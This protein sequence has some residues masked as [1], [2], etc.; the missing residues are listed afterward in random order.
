MVVNYRYNTATL[1]YK[2][3]VHLANGLLHYST[4]CMS[5][6]LLYNTISQKALHGTLNSY[7]TQIEFYGHLLP[8]QSTLNGLILQPYI[9]VTG[10]AYRNAIMFCVNF[11]FANFARADSITKKRLQ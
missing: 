8:S 3:F 6:V 5:T 9:E 4:L 7:T 1:S 11:T 2:S 10:F